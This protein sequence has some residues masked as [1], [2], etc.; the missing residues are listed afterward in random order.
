MESGTAS[1][2]SS[3]PL[4][5]AKVGRNA[6]ISYPNAYVARAALIAVALTLTSPLSAQLPTPSLS[7]IYPTG[8]QAGT[9]FQIELSSSSGLEHADKLIFNHPGIKATILKSAPSRI[10]PKGKLSPGKFTVTIDKSVK[11][12]VYELR[13][14][15]SSG[16]SNSRAFIVSDLRELNESGSNKSAKAAMPLPLD[17]VVNGRCDSGSV[18]YYKISLKKGQRIIL[19]CRARS[20]DS[21]ADAVITLFNISGREL[22]KNR[23]TRFG[24]PLIDFTS[25]KDADYHV[26]ISD[27]LYAGAATFNYRLTVT[28]GPWIDFIHP[29]A[30]QA[31]QSTKLT[32]YGR[33]LPNPSSTSIIINGQTLQKTTINYKAT[34]NPSSTT[35]HATLASREAVALNAQTFSIT[36]NKHSNPVP[37]YIVPEKIA[38]QAVP[39]GETQSGMTVDLPTNYVGTFGVRGA[40]DEIL[41][42]AKKGQKLWIDVYSQRLGHPTDPLIIIQRATKS[43]DGKTNFSEITSS[44]D[45]S[46]SKDGKTIR[47]LDPATLFTAPADGQ[48]RAIVRDQYASG[49]V[50]PRHQFMVTLRPPKPDYRLIATPITVLPKNKKGPAGGP[51]ATTLYRGGSAQIKVTAI[52]LEGFNEEILIKTENLPKGVAASSASIAKGAGDTYISLTAAVDAPGWG[53]PIKITGQ[54]TLNGKPV[55]RNVL[56][57]VPLWAG[58]APWRLSNS[59]DL[60][61]LGNASPLAVAVQFGENKP[62]PIARGQKKN[63]P[64]KLIKR[65][66]YKGQIKLNPT[67]IPN[68]LKNLIKVKGNITVTDAKPNANV[69]ITIDKKLKPGLYTLAMVGDTKYN[70]VKDKDAPKKAAAE[71]TRIDNLIKQINAELKKAKADKNNDLITKLTDELK[72]AQAA[73]KDAQNQQKSA[74]AAA[75]PRNIQL[76]VTSSILTIQVTEP[77]KPKP[78]P[79]PKPNP[80]AAKKQPSKK[81]AKK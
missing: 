75:K 47:T 74:A 3:I 2:H 53:G 49:P 45:Q 40:Q 55:T 19:Q 56:G 58:A 22:T 50:D 79:Q 8:G 33:N 31:G 25:P 51:T 48:Y 17:T 78:K 16:I 18:D 5:L 64:I 7:S 14:A 30:V 37:L 41:F 46:L 77:A 27:F 35:N 69:E 43:K 68:A 12:G 21:P 72:Q 1:S 66:N 20:I 44:D 36:N 26:Q 11:P 15:G 76:R 80:K 71:K 38:Y 24:D 70:F 6:M 61:V 73:Q 10:Y 59:V 32:V 13:A 42:T 81:N 39:A 67:G 23:N 29:P 28:T 54:S 52:R 57:S 62:F 60:G 65:G 34:P 63:V 9:T 4:H